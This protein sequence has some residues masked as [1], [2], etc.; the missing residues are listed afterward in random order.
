MRSSATHSYYISAKTDVAGLGQP[1]ANASR[2]TA[3]EP[4][5][6][7]HLGATGSWS[8]LET[9]SLIPKSE[10][11]MDSHNHKVEAALQASPT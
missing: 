9:Q 8:Q 10:S 6:T 5:L 7:S 1:L 4:A 2:S 11:P 3:Q